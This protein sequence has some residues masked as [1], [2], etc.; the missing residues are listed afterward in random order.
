MDVEYEY[1]IMMF[2]KISIKEVNKNK[3]IFFFVLILGFLIKTSLSEN[4]DV[5][6]AMQYVLSLEDS[7]LSIFM[8]SNE[9]PKESTYCIANIVKK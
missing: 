2:M 6:I 7:L 4:R 9:F 3:E 8:E 1:L 5:T